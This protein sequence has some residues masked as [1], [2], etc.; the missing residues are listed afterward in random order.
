MP[1]KKPFLVWLA[2]LFTPS[3]V[4]AGGGGGFLSSILIVAAIVVV[5]IV[6]P[7]A[8][9]TF[10]EGGAPSFLGGSLVPTMTVEG[11]GLITLAGYGPVVE[12]IAAGVAVNGFA[13]D[14]ALCATGVTCNGDYLSGTSGSTPGASTPG[15]STAPSN[16]LIPG[17][18]CYSQQNACGQAYQ[19]IIDYAAD[20][21]TLTCYQ[22]NA[23]TVLLPATPPPDTGCATTDG[24]CAITHYDCSAGTSANPVANADSWTWACNG[25]NGGSTA[26]CSE[27][28]SWTEY[29]TGANDAHPWQ[30]WRY[31]NSHPTVYEYL[32]TDLSTCGPLA[33]MDGSCN[34]FHWGC[35]TGTSADN[36][37]GTAGPWTWSCKGANGGLDVA[38]SQSNEVT[39]VIGGTGPG[40][41]GPGSSGSCIVKKGIAQRLCSGSTPGSFLVSYDNCGGEIARAQCPYGCSASA[42]NAPPPISLAPFQANINT[43]TKGTFT[44]TG[45][46][47]VRPVLVKRGDPTWLYWNVKNASSCAVSG[48]N[49]DAWNLFASG[50]DGQQTQPIQGHTIFTLHCVPLLGAQPPTAVTET[51]N[52]DVVPI[53]QE[54]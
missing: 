4:L 28:R 3:V 22:S 34:T 51:Q 25:I 47:Q 7:E 50:A 26:S 33:R 14:A 16:S 15:G 29:C 42:C 20:G 24:S 53:F 39:G 27:A 35:N 17:E 49:G 1:K 6:A 18:P 41:T 46:L 30:I 48:D 36:T 37:G 32:R 5:A 11:G 23:P 52:V 10:G 40:G 43:G 21:T 2:T 12:S 13:V 9:V 19:G 8:L 54:L 38:C 45:D 31:D 44:A